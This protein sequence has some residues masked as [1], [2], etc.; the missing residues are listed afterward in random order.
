ML[1]HTA[2]IQLKRINKITN[3]TIKVLFAESNSSITNTNVSVFRAC[4]ILNSRASYI[5]ITQ[6]I[7][8]NTLN[9]VKMLIKISLHS[10]KV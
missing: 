2:K 7:Y 3:D 4:I 9:S 5:K 10:L 1:N 6:N 8:N